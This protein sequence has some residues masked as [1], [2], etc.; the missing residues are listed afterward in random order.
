MFTTHNEKPIS[1]LEKAIFVAFVAL[2]VWMPLPFASNQAWAWAL[3]EV[4]VFVLAA[5]MCV[6][7]LRGRLQSNKVVARSRPVLVLF[8]LWLAF[9]LLQI[10]PLPAFL[11][12]WLSPQRLAAYRL[13]DPDGQWLTISQSVADTQ[14]F[15]MKSLM[16]V[17]I[18]ILALLLLNSKRRIRLMVWAIICSALFQAMYGSIMTLSGAEYGFLF[19]KDAYVGHATGT[20]VNRNHL[21]AYLNLGLAIGIGVLVGGLGRA[22]SLRTAKQ[23]WRSIVLLLLSKKTILRVF[24]ALMTVALVL[25]HSRMGNTSF[26]V[27]LTVT[28]LITLAL[29]SHARRTMA[30]LIVS[31]IIIDIMILSAWFGL[32]KVT[33]RL[34]QTS[35][36]SEQRD[37]VSKYTYEQWQ[38]YLIVG[39][40]AGTFEYVFPGYRG[41]EFREYYDYAHNDVLQITSE[42]G[43][44]G[45]VLLFGGMLL[46]WF[47]A[48]RALTK[49]R[50]PFMI[51]LGFAA[52]MG[53]MALSIHSFVDFSLQMPANAATFMLLLSLGWI[54]R[55]HASQQGR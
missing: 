21:A 45:A 41:P 40:G 3:A 26:F 4:W 28:A 48:L 18:F 39:S 31:I 24:I 5:G 36:E 25:T 43:V 52:M 23:R 6:L 46:S 51:G 19:K 55:H 10:V 54:A 14:I 53:I 12:E 33:Q 44:I 32:E 13:V 38:D 1:R 7:Y 9:L 37:E 49:R 22:Q 2:L 15:F 17:L 20:F 16:Y 34:E 29:T 42:T 50:D 27:A 8:G 35:F 47:T 30:I 11:I